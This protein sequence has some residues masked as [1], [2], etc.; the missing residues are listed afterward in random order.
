MKYSD[1]L[2]VFGLSENKHPDEKTLRKTYLLLSRKHHPDK[3]GDPIRF[4]EI[5]TAYD[6]LSNRYDSE[7]DVLKNQRNQRTQRDAFF[8]GIFGGFND[9]FSNFQS[10]ETHKTDTSKIKRTRLTVEELFQGTTRKVIVQESVPCEECHG[11]GTGSRVKCSDCGGK[12]SRTLHRKLPTGSQTTRT[13][14]NTCMGRG[15]I[16]EGSAHSCASCRGHRVISKRE[17]KHVRVPRGVPNGTKIIVK[18]GDSPTVLEIKY[19][20]LSHS[21]WNGWTLSKDR[22][23]RNTQIIAL[24]TALLGGQIET[25]HPGTHK[26]I[27]VRIPPNTQPDDEIYIKDGGLPAC[28]EAKLPPSDACIQVKIRLPTIPQKHTEN[29]RRFFTALRK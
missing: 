16:G 20:P 10:N 7:E 23:L 14:C 24:E 18:D 25:T 5:Q 3:G 9:I 21:D 13:I 19:P 27:T 26:T 15:G 4:K 29:T 1:A 11:T 28:S 17:T 12:G 2:R 6:V 8:D 22:I